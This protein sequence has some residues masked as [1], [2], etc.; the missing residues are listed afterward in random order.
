MLGDECARTE[1]GRSCRDGGSEPTLAERWDIIPA[2]GMSIPCPYLGAALKPT[3]APRGADR[4]C[5]LPWRCGG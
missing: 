5:S 1:G 2:A 4:N 3:P